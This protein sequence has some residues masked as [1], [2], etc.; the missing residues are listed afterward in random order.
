MTNC[1]TDIELVK[2]VEGNLEV[3]DHESIEKHLQQCEACQREIEIHCQDQ[4]LFMDLAS[5]VRQNLQSKIHNAFGQ[6]E[7]EFKEQIADR[8]YII[9]RELYRGG[10]GVV[11]SAVQKANDRI[12][13]VKRLKLQSQTEP[14]QIARFERE[15]EIATKLSHPNIVTVFDNGSVADC[16]YLVMEFVNGLSLDRYVQQNFQE[17]ENEMIT[18]VHFD[19]VLELFNKIC[20]AVSYAHRLGIIHRD[21]KPNNILIDQM[22][23][24]KILDFGLAKLVEDPYRDL[25]QTGQFLGTLAYASPEQVQPGAR[26]AV[27]TRTDVYSLGVILYEMMTGGLPYAVDTGLSNAIK[28]IIDQQPTL[29]SRINGKLDNDIETITLKALAKDPARRYQ[30]VDQL[31]GDIDLYLNGLPIEAKR[32]HSLYVLYKTFCRFKGYAVAAGLLA[33]TIVVALGVSLW[34]WDQAIQQR[35]LATTAQS[36][37]SIAREEAELQSYVANIVASKGAVLNNDVAEAKR[38]LD[39][40]PLIYR[41]WEWDYFKLRSDQSRKTINVH[42]LYVIDFEFAPENSWVVSTAGD[43]QLK[44]WSLKDQRIIHQRQFEIPIVD[45]AL[46]LDQKIAAV[47]FPDNEIQLIRLDGMETV[48]SE[49]FEFP[50][51]ALAYLNQNEICVLKHPDTNEP[52]VVVWNWRSNEKRDM[53]LPVES[54]FDITVYANLKVLVAGAKPGIWNP[55]DSKFEQ[56]KTNESTTKMSFLGALNQYALVTPGHEVIIVDADSLKE[57]FRLKGHSMQINEVIAV[58]EK[59]IVTSSDDRTIRLWNAKNGNQKTLL[60]GHDQSVYKLE[61]LTE[62]EFVSCSADATFKIWDIDTAQQPRILPGHSNIVRD[63][64]FSPTGKWLASCS[65]DNQVLLRNPVDATVTRVLEH[66]S[67]LFAISFRDDNVLATGG[68]ELTIRLWDL[69]N[70]TFGELTGHEDRIHSLD[71]SPDGKWLLSGSRDKTVRVWD[72]DAKQCVRV[73]RDHNECIHACAFHP[74][75]P[76]FASRCHFHIRLWDWN[77]FEEIANVKQRI[78]PEDYSLAFNPAEKLLVSGS[79]IA[80]FG[81]GFVSVF[82]EANLKSVGSLEQ[83]NTPVNAVAFFPTGQRAV[84]A[85]NESIK[86]WDMENLVE[87]ANLD[88]V[89]AAPFCVTVSPDNR[90]VAAGLVNGEVI[91]WETPKG[92]D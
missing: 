47:A 83:H 12:V 36:N 20:H 26:T 62:K 27:D 15:I 29:P 85:S 8:G 78:S 91:V 49:T 75:K 45:I 46:S 19:S 9:D 14:D 69:T 23:E 42:D 31:S 4:D 92:H 86:I 64:E 80:G 11:Y 10:Q 30:N 87:L 48:F 77:T 55:L 72:V 5:V 28:N 17:S 76:V 71:F 82:D 16:S 53:Q 68:D 39:A 59:T 40:A 58:D 51:K 44:V 34:F 89:H 56:I 73:I 3:D 6:S 1:P 90:A 84:S 35:D 24:P 65:E 67:A 60:L 21:L 18:N 33:M 61:Q 57:K 7:L 32:D 74:T 22:G 50:I 38:R 37:E 52:G 88:S 41:G 79:S 81:R 13:A 66:S 70:G 63:I 2:H 43:N 25:T 54:V